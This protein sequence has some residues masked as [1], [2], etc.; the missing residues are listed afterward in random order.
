MR[1]LIDKQAAIDAI[2]NYHIDTTDIDS[3]TED[4]IKF[5]M[6]T[7]LNIIRQLPPI[8]PKPRWIPVSERLPKPYTWVY[9][10]CHSLVNDWE[11]WVIDTI[12]EPQP[13][14]SP[15]SDWGNIEMLNNGE[16]EVIAWME[17]ISPEPYKASPTGAESE[18]KE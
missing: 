14:D 4:S 10:T 6:A 16:C 8:E 11:D 18:D 12:Y 5:G 2:E 3:D 9:V 7:A 15:Y 17:W 1:V 13:K